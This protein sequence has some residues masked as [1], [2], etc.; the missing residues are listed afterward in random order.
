MTDQQAKDLIEQLEAQNEQ[1]KQQNNLLMV[2][3][4][5]LEK[6]KSDLYFNTPEC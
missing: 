4:D 1:L 3:S 2:I 6:I 5:K